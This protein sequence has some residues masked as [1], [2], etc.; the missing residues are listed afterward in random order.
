[1]S[2]WS[3]LKNNPRLREIYTQRLK[4]IRLIREFFWSAGFEET[5][6]PAA[7]RFPG[8]EPYL[9]PVP[10]LFH[11]SA[12]VE[13][14]FYLQTSPE[15]AMKKLLAAG[16]GKIFQLCRC[17]R[18]FEQ[19]GGNHN[20]EF[21]MIEWYR[22]PGTLEEIM[23]DTEKLFKYVAEKSGIG[24]VEHK[25]KKINVVGGWE[26]LSMRE[27]WKK[28][29]GVE[30]D[31]YLTSEKMAEL[32][33]ERGYSVEA[34]EPYEDLFYKI[35]LNEIETKLGLEK[36][37]MIYDYPEQM[38]SL[39]RLSKNDPRYAERFELYIAGLELA[40]AFGEL[41]DAVEQKKRLEADKEKRKQLGKETWPVDPDFI[42]AIKQIGEA[43][44]PAGA[45]AEAGGIALG[46][47]RLVMLFTGAKDINEVIFQAVGDQLD[48]TF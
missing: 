3:D 18:D 45:L 13:N 25:G 27:V 41:T 12:G 33:R 6:T 47:D 28:Y 37:V 9:N 31:D 29:V 34:S 16:F 11:D 8:Q 7:V 2:N 21:T 44:L 26:R 36:P 1:M 42:N 14:K 4:M 15:F 19:F 17:F 5:A 38:C 35:F 23:D 30:L 40:N 10:V 46:V 20:T 24:A 39:S 22:A 32:A 43:G 48:K